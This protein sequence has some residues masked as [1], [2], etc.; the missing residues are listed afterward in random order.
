MITAS[1]F[2][3]FSVTPSIS[4]PGVTDLVCSSIN[5]PSNI[6]LDSNGTVYGSRLT[7]F[8]TSITVDFSLVCDPTL[9]SLFLMMNQLR[10]VRIH[11][12]SRVP[13]K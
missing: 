2:G 13:S 6:L 8:P 4:D 5:L 7:I 12:L 10:S 9:L 11:H 1:R 3:N